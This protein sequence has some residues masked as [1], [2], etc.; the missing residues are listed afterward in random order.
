MKLTAHEC[1]VQPIGICHSRAASRPQMQCVYNHQTV[2]VD[3]VAPRMSNVEPWYSQRACKSGIAPRA[4]A[5]SSQPLPARGS[6]SPVCS[7]LATSRPSRTWSTSA[8]ASSATPLHSS[9]RIPATARTTTRR[10]MPTPAPTRARSARRCTKRRIPR[11]PPSSSRR[12]GSSFARRSASQRSRRSP[13]PSTGSRR[14]R[15]HLFAPDRT[16]SSAGQRSA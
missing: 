10:R 11:T 1:Q 13:R 8:R 12:L 4:R 3:A 16:R 7:A 6:C 2:V 14:R 5:V 9:A 15:R